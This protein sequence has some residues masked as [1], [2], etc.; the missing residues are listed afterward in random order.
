MM[1]A[2]ADKAGTDMFFVGGSTCFDQAYIEKTIRAIK[3]NSNKPVIIFPGGVNAVCANADAILFLS[4]LTSNNPYFIIGGQVLGAIATKMAGIE[5]ISTA[6]LIVEPGG[7]AGWMS[8]NKPLLRNKPEIAIGYALAAQFIGFKMVY[9]EAGSGVANS[10]PDEMIRKVRKFI[11]IP[12]IIGGGVTAPEDAREKVLAGAD[13]L[14]QGTFIEETVMQDEGA[15]LAEVIQSLKEAG[16]E[17][18]ASCSPT[19]KSQDVE[20]AQTSDE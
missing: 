1:A 3:K 19:T 10:V 18:L 16:R 6:Y 14:V 17:R 2:Y 5:A 8:D 9:M 4:I 13:I 15:A 11:D 7:V 20:V 12:L